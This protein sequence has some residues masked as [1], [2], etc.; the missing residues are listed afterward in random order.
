MANQEPTRQQR[1]VALLLEVPNINLSK[2]TQRA[3]IAGAALD[4]RLLAQI[5][6]SD[7]AQTFLQLLIPTLESY[8]RLENGGHATQAILQSARNFLGPKHH[9]ECDDLLSEYGV[10][11]PAVSPPTPTPQPAPSRSYNTGAIRQLL[12]ETLSEDDLNELCMDYFPDV[13]ES[14]TAGINKRQRIQQLLEYCSKRSRFA[15]LLDR[16]QTINPTK[17]AELEHTL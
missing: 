6:F 8:G 15:E 14:F 5:N 11:P 9:E 13:H 3:L 10:S 12:R 7:S 16:V 17:F 1:I 2:D 4:A